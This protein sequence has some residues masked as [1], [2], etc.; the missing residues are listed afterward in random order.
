MTRDKTEEK[1]H[2]GANR[3]RRSPDFSPDLSPVT[4]P[5]QDE[6]LA[7]NLPALV[8]QPHGGALYAGGV[9]GHRGAGGRPR[10]EVRERALEIVQGSI[11]V[12]DEIA[13]GGKRDADRI[14]ALELAA[15][16]SGLV[17][18]EPAGLQQVIIL[19]DV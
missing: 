14:D 15:K 4:E 10:S 8:P 13:G 1:G 7:P 12:L 6:K 9:P 3:C 11:H 18:P 5:S 16:I 19:V 2:Q 17:G